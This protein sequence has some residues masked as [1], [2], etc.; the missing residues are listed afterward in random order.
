MKLYHYTDLN[1]LKG[2]VENNLLWATSLQ[3]LNDSE[4]LNHG[5]ECIENALPNLKNNIPK[6]YVSSIENAM[7]RFSRRNFEHVYNISFC[8]E[9]ELLSQW[10]GY[11]NTH[12]VCI[13]F[14]SD[15]LLESL[16]FECFN[17]VHKDVSY[18]AKGDTLE[19]ETQLIKLFKE[20]VQGHNLL[21]D[22][23]FQRLHT[24][25]FADSTIPFFKNERFSE[26][27]EYRI[28]VYPFRGL[29]EVKFRVSKNGLIPY[30]E[31]KAK[32]KIGSPGNVRF[33][34]IPI[35]KVTIAPSSN[36]EFIK[37]GVERFLKYNYYNN[38]VVETS[39]TPYRG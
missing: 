31:L 21:S 29:T 32:P 23:D 12:G 10:R 16:D 13:Q 1:G 6:E 5:I 35:D 38:T 2:I 14:D 36:A 20:F 4:E 3:F 27:K 11:A 17:V 30:I 9:A 15:N 34:K 19:V 18:C 25:K 7:E 39:L 8:R 26:E 22:G 37:N 28:V 24:T 33:G